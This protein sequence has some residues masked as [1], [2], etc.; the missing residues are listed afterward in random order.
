MHWVKLCFSKLRPYPGAGRSKRRR[1]AFS[2]FWFYVRVKLPRATMLLSVQRTAKQGDQK[3]FLTPKL[4][5]LPPRYFKK[6]QK[7]CRFVF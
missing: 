1:E 3:E 6:C 7:M 5:L 2:A 4:A